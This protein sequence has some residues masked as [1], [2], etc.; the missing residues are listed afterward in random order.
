MAEFRHRGAHA[1]WR[2]RCRCHRPRAGVRKR[3]LP[4]D[5]LLHAHAQAAGFAAALLATIAIHQM[6]ESACLPART[7][8]G[9]GE[10]EAW[11]WARPQL[12]SVMGK[13]AVPILHSFVRQNLHMRVN[14]T[15]FF[16]SALVMLDEAAVEGTRGFELCRLQ[17][18]RN[19]LG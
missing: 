13:R 6:N 15:D 9:L 18:S 16:C 10:L 11:L 12:G 14:C 17:D 2:I 8:A 7:G 5:R 4:G 1:S 19:A 3:M